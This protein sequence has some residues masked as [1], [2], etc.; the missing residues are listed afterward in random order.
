MGGDYIIRNHPL[1]TR[2]A[3]SD[4]TGRYKSHL[5]F[6][7]FILTIGGIDYNWYTIV[8]RPLLVFHL[9]R[10]S[11]R[12]LNSLIR[13][14]DYIKYSLVKFAEERYRDY[15]R[16]LLHQLDKDEI[17]IS[18]K[19]DDLIMSNNLRNKKAIEDSLKNI[20]SWLY[21][22][23]TTYILEQFIEDMS[24]EYPY[25]DQIK[26]RDASEFETGCD[27]YQFNNYYS[28][29]TLLGVY[30]IRPIGAGLNDILD[31][32][33]EYQIYKTISEIRGDRRENA[34]I[35]LMMDIKKWYKRK[36]NKKLKI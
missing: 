20:V 11:L 4:E 36:Y 21:Q 5:E 16:I 10:R 25:F 34:I 15:I 24:D 35:S 28:I 2:A 18:M 3:Y 7:D 17:R 9:D 8:K 13:S 6:G 1:Y 33:L 32:N 19:R 12:E 26:L 29:R 30:H 23:R 27:S 31:D 14:N 22:P